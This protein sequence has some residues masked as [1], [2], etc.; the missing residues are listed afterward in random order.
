MT[1]YYYY[2]YYYM[3]GLFES[4]LVWPFLSHQHRVWHTK[5]SNLMMHMLL[6]GLLSTN[7]NYGYVYANWTCFLVGF[8][9]TI[10]S[11]TWLSLRCLCFVKNNPIALIFFYQCQDCV[12]FLFL[13]FLLF[14]K[15]IIIIIIIIIITHGGTGGWGG[16]L[17]QRH[18]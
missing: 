7:V 15:S 1:Y 2:Y 18:F 4:L 9:I 11:L 3:R 16:C 5:L 10:R 17:N 12:L 13:L 8:Y 14:F 6:W